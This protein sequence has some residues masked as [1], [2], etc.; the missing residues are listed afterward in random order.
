MCECVCVCEHISLPLSLPPL[1]IQT[2][3]Y[4]YIYNTI[5][6]CVFMYACIYICIVGHGVLFAQSVYAC[7][8]CFHRPVLSST[9]P[10]SPIYLVFAL[11]RCLL[12]QEPDFVEYEL[13]SYVHTYIHA[14]I[15]AN[16]QHISLTYS[17]I[18]LYMHLCS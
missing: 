2:Y 5:C 10:T 3:L 1:Y 6:I 4:I 7:T 14:H 8:G 18:S 17:D 13:P 11:H 12:S 16:A 9:C 15:C